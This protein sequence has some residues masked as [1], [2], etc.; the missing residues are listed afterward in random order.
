MV[1]L[2]IF[3]HFDPYAVDIFSEIALAITAP[4]DEK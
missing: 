4:N 2:K 3:K 1:C